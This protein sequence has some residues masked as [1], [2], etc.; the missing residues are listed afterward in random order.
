VDPGPLFCVVTHHASATAEPSSSRTTTLRIR[1][2]CQDPELYLVRLLKFS[3]IQFIHTKRGM[4][5]S[6]LA[7]SMTDD[8]VLHPEL[9]SRIFECMIDT[10]E[11]YW[12]S[13]ALKDVVRV[14]KSWKVR[15]P[16]RIAESPVSYMP[17]RRARLSQCC[18]V[19]SCFPIYLVSPALQHTSYSSVTPTA[20]IWE[21]RR[22]RS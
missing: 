17:N 8:H 10:T 20:E 14:C 13:A 15:D 6:D 16:S 11:R 18:I 19:I 3:I 4:A 22:T 12:S 9:W 1:A 2:C 7:A 21:D 5:S